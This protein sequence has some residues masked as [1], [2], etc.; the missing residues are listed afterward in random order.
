MR[1]GKERKMSKLRPLNNDPTTHTFSLIQFGM[2]ELKKS[3]NPSQIDPIKQ[4]KPPI[5]GAF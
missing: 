1:R 4:K 3:F 2:R 5:T